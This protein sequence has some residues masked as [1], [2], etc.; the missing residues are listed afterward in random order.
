MHLSVY[1]EE[2]KILFIHSII[3]TKAKPYT[4]Q[5]YLGLRADCG[6]ECMLHI[7]NILAQLLDTPVLAH[8]SSTCSA[9]CLCWYCLLRH[10]THIYSSTAS[11]TSRPNT[12][13]TSAYCLLQQ[14]GGHSLVPVFI[15]RVS[16]HQHHIE[17]T[18]QRGRDGSIGGQVLRGVVAALRIAACHHCGAC[19]EL[20]YHTCLGH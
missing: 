8:T 5:K 16:Q 6:M 15:R 19:V 9:L 18:Q 14:K 13:S 11:T 12:S 4:Y 17:A 1:K 20:Y 7:R 3:S 10:I 2:I